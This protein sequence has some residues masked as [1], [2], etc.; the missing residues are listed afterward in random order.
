MPSH[1][2]RWLIGALALVSV[3]FFLQRNV[4]RGRIGTLPTNASPRLTDVVATDPAL[5]LPAGVSP[6]EKIANAIAARARRD[7][8]LTKT[9]AFS[10]W[11]TDWRRAE[12]A[13]QPSLAAIGRELAVAR[14]SALKHLIET[15]PQRALDLAVPVGLRTELPAAVQE[16][17]EKRVDRR[18]DLEVNIS[19]RGADAQVDRIARLSDTSYRAFVFG[20]REHQATK[21]GLPL[22]GIAIED[23]AA[24]DETPYRVL[25]DGE[26]ANRG[27]TSEQTALWIGAELSV[28]ADAAELTQLGE[29]L[30]AAES[31]VGPHVADLRS[32]VPGG[33]STA[34]PAT[35]E[36]TS[37]PSWILGTKRVLWLKIDFADDPGAAY[38]DAEILAGASATNDFYV[39]NSQ[40][41]TTLA[42]SILPAVLRM[43]KDKAYYSTSGSTNGELYTAA[44]DA[45]KAYDAAN[46]GTGAWDPE[47]FDRYLIIHKR[48]SVYLY[49]GVA[50][51][52]GPR[53]GLNNAIGIGTVG[54][55]LGH[56]Q[57]LAHSHYWLPTG[58]SPV[59]AG[60]HV[61][62]GDVFDIMGSGTMHFNASQKYK[63]GYLDNTSVTTV[64]QAGTYR[65]ARHDDKDAAGIRGLR[66][67][68]GDLGY[69]Y[70]VEHRRTAPTSLSSS[71]VDRL[72]NGVLIHWGTEKS[73]KFTS[74]QGTYLL[75]GTPGS[76]GGAS[77]APVRT[78]ETFVDPDAGITIKPLA[79][80]GTAPNEY[81][82][83]QVAFGATDGNRNPSLIADVPT[84]TITARSNVV[85]NASGA[86]PDGDAVYFR[87]DF[88]DGSLQPNLSSI[89]RRFL[90]GG[91][92]SLRVSA[93]DGK[94]GI[95]AKT[96]PF[97]VVDPLVS[98]TLRANGVT[99]NQL[100][101]VIFA[102]GKFVA[103]GINQ[104]ILSSSD[105]VTWTRVTFPTGNSLTG[106]AHNGAR[107]VTCGYR[108]NNTTQKGLAAYSD[109]GTN[110]TLVNIDTGLAQFWGIAHG[111]G[112]FV[113]VG[114]GGIIYSSADGVTWTAAASGITTVLRA[115][116]FADGLFVITGDNGRVFVS[117]D[118]VNWT[119]R[120]LPSTAGFWGAT[121]HNGVWYT[122]SGSTTYSSPDAVTWTR[123]ASSSASSLSSFKIQSVGGVLLTGLNSGT[124]DFGENAQTWASVQLSTLSASG[125]RGTAASDRTIVVV[126][127]S[128]L[129][130]S[131]DLPTLPSRTLPPPTLRIEADAIKVAVGKKNVLSA[132]GAG[133]VKLELY[134]NGTKVSEIDGSAGALSWTPSA[135]GNYL[136]AVR[137]IDASG[138]SVVSTSYPAVAAFAN[139]KWRNPAPSGA[140]LRGAVRV[141]DKWWIVG[142]GGTL[143]TLDDA[144]NFTPIDFSTTQQLNAIA[145]ANGRFV[146]AT[147]DLD[148]ATKEDIGGLWTSADG[149]SWTPFLT[150]ALDSANLNT[151]IYAA[152]RWICLGTGGTVVTSTDGINWPRSSSGI[153][154]SLQG[155]TFGNGLVVA[156]A[157]G[158][159]IITSPDGLVW[160]ERTSGV[161]TDLRAVTFANG[162]F[163]AAGLSGVILTSANGTTWT[164]ATSGTTT[165]LYGAGFVK[166]SFVVGGDN[167]T[168]LSSTTGAVWAAAALGGTTS[169][170][171]YI[172]NSGDEGLL[173][174]RLGEIYAAT[175]ATSWRRLTRGTGESM[176]S[177]IYA[178]SRFVA[179]GQTTDAITR[180]IGVP[181]SVSSDGITWTRAATTTGFTNVNDVTFAR[182]LYVTVGDTGRIFTSTNATA[183]TQRTSPV[184]TQLNAIAGS[185]SGFVAGGA[186]GAILSSPDGTTWTSQT[187]GTTQPLRAAAFGAGR[188]VMVGDNGAIVQSAD[189]TSWATAT[190]GVT[191][192]LLTVGWWEEVG[193]IAAGNGGTL[194]NSIDG[195]TWQQRETGVAEN[196]GAV[197][198]TPI[199]YVASGGTLGTLLVSLD[200]VSWSL[201]ALPADKMIRG[202]AASP[203]AIVAVGDN[204]AMLTFEIVDSTPAPVIAAQPV[205]RTASPGDAVT[206]SI[207]AQNAAGAV[208][209]WM[210]DG[211]VIIGANSPVYTIP[212]VTTG[213]A[214][215]Y[216]VSVTTATGTVVSTAAN[217]TFGA[218]VD[219]GRL[220]N[221]SI[222]TSLTSAADNFT[223]GVV[224]GGAG[225][226]G[227]KALLVRA[228]GPALSA[229]GVQD[230]LAD[231]KLE[232]FTGSTKV[233]ENDN[234]GGS[235]AITAAMAQVGA[236][237]FASAA[238]RDAAISLP[239]LASGQNSAI[240]SGTGTGSVIAELYDA[241]PTANFTAATPRLVNVSVR[242]H[243]GTGVI[244]GFVVGGSTARTV[245]IRAIGPTLGVFG[246]TGVVAD[247]QLALFSGATQIGAN[248]NWGGT[249]ALATAFANVGAF[250]LAGD[251]K[252]AALLAT[253]EP[254]S[255]TVQV[256]GVA[257]TTGVALV[258]VYE[259]P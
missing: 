109:D 156:V 79:V 19:H 41:K 211:A 233:G 12:I 63:L 253:L 130:Y 128:G 72:R 141:G 255:Y 4:P 196:I 194:L 42:F 204:G 191:T 94:G 93:H 151:V 81:I 248:D 242:K 144:G 246:V 68:P 162:T 187:S 164:R 184:T 129:I 207:S 124:I 168:V 182:N 66:I 209:Q 235:A 100:N 37:P 20:R 245:L 23:A 11:L 76:A 31:I 111:A 154:T 172:A 16:Q 239:S 174:G 50:N 18:G 3:G 216:A 112:R 54:H 202:L 186:G 189:G 165:N 228:A 59:G 106:I 198:K 140:E 199:G 205:L 35:A 61:E 163:V 43:P 251:S 14:R 190:S 78:G 249:A 180:T 171:F 132:S 215:A 13:D 114:D 10:A 259:V 142:G 71:Q 169:G 62:Y 257:G 46:G 173:V 252:D 147:T 74:G 166:G 40:G 188:Y 160:T 167:G 201:S 243:L 8:A 108:F 33:G 223:F 9:A 131:T 77:D 73:P 153:T 224:V 70:W 126:G 101:D 29:Q 241:T 157:V 159:R 118:G 51:V 254:G 102:G 149:Y 138:A 238:S 116:T 110:W 221:L 96:I 83:V 92:Y 226:S 178:G 22:H 212:V 123:V 139:W 98:W 244:A 49:G 64:T 150:G 6:G 145:Y 120:S 240:I 97:K 85:F 125:L 80:G 21:L 5:C 136:L 95:A 250:A 247:P 104:T 86:D 28:I 256:S 135:I 1:P 34:T 161:T 113:A 88:G 155:V 87:W 89:T 32:G 44:R 193:F 107:Y 148:G 143:L 137:G 236:F 17:L 65:I 48:I 2:R 69:E 55:E 52:G 217:L 179:V 99:P 56:T 127:N 39:A 258:E 219:P 158:G 222:R 119:N 206:F 170:T 57:S 185:A 121:K 105:G 192:A 200:G 181:I 177:V 24:L 38:T 67:S 225:T 195:I 208:Y 152:N 232:F 115:V 230:V 103:V 218:A 229:F 58:T 227:G 203:T 82:D 27:L 90:K 45:A 134:A 176:F 183:W 220:I 15:D 25:D 234:W 75:D 237:P 7:D 197:T 53:V 117:S 91:D 30:V 122:R 47:K 26:K 210:K 36:V 175:T 213:N 133:F 84:G 214:G 231:P 146:I 60:T